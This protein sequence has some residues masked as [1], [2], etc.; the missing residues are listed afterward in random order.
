[1]KTEQVQFNQ[2]TSMFSTQG[3]WVAK[4]GL[5]T[6]CGMTFKGAVSVPKDVKTI[7]AVFS[8]K[9][10]AHDFT[11]TRRFPRYSGGQPVYGL[12][13][14]YTFMLS[15]RMLIERMYKRGHRYVRIEY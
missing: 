6:M 11:I 13:I 4:G 10:S 14:N 7:Y 9:R 5:A 2:Q 3:P 1:M 15:A 8:D 12:D